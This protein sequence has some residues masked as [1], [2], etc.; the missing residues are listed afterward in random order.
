MVILHNND[1]ETVYNKGGENK[2]KKLCIPN[3]SYGNN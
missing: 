1:L 2:R 3:E